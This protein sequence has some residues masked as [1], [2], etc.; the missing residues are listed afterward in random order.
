MES[1]WRKAGPHWLWMGW[2]FAFCWI[3]VCFPVSDTDLWWHLAAGQRILREGKLPDA[4]YLTSGSLGRP[5]WDVHWLFQC[6]VAAVYPF[7]GLVGV[8]AMKCALFALGAC[9]LLQTAELESGGGARGLGAALVALFVCTGRGWAFERPVIFTL[10]FMALFL[11]LLERYLKEPRIRLLLILAGL[12]LLWTNTQP[13]FPLGPFMAACYL[14]GEAL[15]RAARRLG[16][17]AIPVRLSDRALCLLALGCLGLCLACL[18]TPY[19]VQPLRIAFLLFGRIDP[20]AD[21]IFSRSVAENLPLWTLE[22]LGDPNAPAIK[23]VAALA[24]ASFWL[25]GRRPCPARLLLLG[26]IF[27]TALM[28]NRNALL[29]CWVAAPFC[30]MHLCTAWRERIARHL[31]WSAR[32]FWAWSA[33]LAAWLVTLA[34]L[35]AFGLPQRAALARPLPFRVPTESVQ[36]LQRLPPGPIFNSVRYGGYLAF[37]LLPQ[38]RPFIDGRLVQ[39][40]PAEFSAYL[41]VLDHP[42]RFDTYADQHGFTFALLPV[43]QPDRYQR[44]A[45][46]LLH[47][48]GWKLLFTDGTELLFGRSALLTPALRLADPGQLAALRARLDERFGKDPEARLTADLHLG[49][50]L[51][52]AGEL[53][54][55]TEVLSALPDPRAGALLARTAYLG[56]QPES[57]RQRALAL[58]SA[59]PGDA[60][61]LSLLA[62]IALDRDDLRG[63]AAW[64]SQALRANP[65]QTEAREI[66]EV[67]QGYSRP[68]TK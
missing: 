3:A 6:A 10:L 24:F 42:E 43:A 20:I 31:P 27:A 12:Q 7:Q 16:W 19:G 17:S 1:A 64:A 65:F 33:P 29:L 36:A 38:R 18:L 45:A 60:A 56:D 63:A 40:T 47:H 9:L 39:K 37:S 55:S 15:A 53:A 34:W 30:A 28:A 26:G 21:S 50:L 62:R 46:R 25:A 68:G 58:L 2:L 57:A 32:A 48:P 59:W 44:L 66:L 11:N 23:Y 49:L 35:A 22:R 41:E 51:L 8:V 67:I 54:G 13:L 5:W 14:A 52:L 61:S 4:E